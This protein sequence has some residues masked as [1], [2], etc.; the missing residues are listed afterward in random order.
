MRGDAP[1]GARMVVMQSAMPVS[2]GARSVRIPNVHGAPRLARQVV[3]LARALAAGDLTTAERLWAEVSATPEVAEVT[4][5]RGP[6]ETVAPTL[7]AKVIASMLRDLH[8]A[9]WQVSFEDSE[10][11]VSGPEW[12]AGATGMGPEEV[13]AEKARARRAMAPRVREEIEEPA[14][15]RFIAGME[16]AQRRPDGGRSILSLF[17]DGPSLAAALRSHGAEAVQPYLDPADSDAG[18]DP[19]TGLRRSDIFRYL[20]MLWSFPTRSPPGRSA[21]FLIRDAGQPNH[22]VCGLLA[23]ASPVPRLGARDCALGWTPAWLEAI[24]LGLD[25]PTEDPVPHLASLRDA[26]DALE[27]EA[28]DAASIADDLARLLDLPSTRSLDALGRTLR[29]LPAG[30]RQQRRRRALQAIIEDLTGEVREGLENVAF[31]DLG[32]SRERAL[33]APEKARRKLEVRR[34]R[35]VEDWRASRRSDAPRQRHRLRVEDFDS[36]DG[37]RA[38]LADPLFVK[39]RATKAAAML[40]VWEELQPREDE[41]PAERL[42]RLA[43]GG[44]RDGFKLTGGRSVARATRVA[45]LERQN[46]LL[47]AQVGDVCVCG[48]IPPYGHL[49]GG[50]LAA[51]AAL[52]ADVARAYHARYKDQVSEITSQMAGRRFTRPADLMALTT[53][54]FYGVGA[55][56]YERLVLPH[57]QGEVRWRFVG[58]SRGHGTLHLS[59]GTTALVDRLLR[60]ETGEHLIT[61][62]FGEGPSERLRKLRDGLARLGVDTDAILQHGM[63][64][65]VFVAELI[66]KATRPGARGRQRAWRTGG[67]RMEDVASHWRQRWLER[68][69]ASRPELLEEIE[70]FS[71]RDLLLGARTSDPAEETDA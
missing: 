64:R 69:L 65:R 1:K 2:F 30:Q 24:V 28:L 56:Q 60:F 48:A 58:Y 67:P 46:R 44:P 51:L 66:E 52:S 53:T 13:R 9:G 36:P 21:T 14:T 8:S 42:R 29:A 10:I 63:P 34:V 26:L 20:R 50:K 71:G 43:L 18:E 16:R 57:S 39:K 12:S 25:F 68:R 5:P 59:A 35:A 40:R 38:A 70:R 55:S 31:D 27:E 3:G 33:E 45:L 7:R 37:R 23:I 54:S 61:S 47:A 22:P 17:A 49:L 4:E 19:D 32:V 41:G 15:Q 11:Y 6:G 62:R